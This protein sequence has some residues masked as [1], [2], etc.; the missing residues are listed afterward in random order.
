MTAR[1]AVLFLLAR[2]RHDE[3]LLP[4]RQKQEEQPIAPRRQKLRRHCS[5]ERNPRLLL[6]TS[7]SLCGA[8]PVER[9]RLIPAKRS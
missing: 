3:H 4:P 2:L 6:T 1:R 5:D 8:R 7:T 9:S